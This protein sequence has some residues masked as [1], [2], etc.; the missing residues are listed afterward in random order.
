[1]YTR[2][3]DNTDFQTSVPEIYDL[4]FVNIASGGPPVYAIPG[5]AIPQPSS[6]GTYRVARH[7]RHQ[8]RPGLGPEAS[9]T[10]HGSSFGVAPS[11][12]DNNLEPGEAGTPLGSR[13]GQEPEHQQYTTPYVSEEI[14][15][16]VPFRSSGSHL[17]HPAPSEARAPLDE[18]DC[19]GT[20]H[21]RGRHNP[22]ENQASDY[23]G[24]EHQTPRSQPTEQERN[25]D[26][27]RRYQADQHLR[28]T[29]SAS[30]GRPIDISV[31][32]GRPEHDF[33]RGARNERNKRRWHGQEPYI[34][35]H[36]EALLRHMGISSA[37]LVIAAVIL[38]IMS[39]GFLAQIFLVS[40]LFVYGRMLLKGPRRLGCKSSAFE[41]IELR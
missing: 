20:T 12:N 22:A 21:R 39:L 30:R 1:M 17:S 2:R 4:S 16:E 26:R 24:L 40:F 8:E 28:D 15:E 36:I 5:S 13:D 34:V 32:A 41:V 18:P 33:E 11:D 37:H 38:S 10:L 23:T 9:D 7:S 35:H 27:P 25:S 14:E 29:Y 6:T 31:N 3:P 19:N